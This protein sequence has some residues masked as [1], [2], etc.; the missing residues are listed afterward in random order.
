MTHPK[1]Y[2]IV[3]SL[4]SLL[5]LFTTLS[6][7]HSVRKLAKRRAAVEA[8]EA[9]GVDTPW[10]I[11]EKRYTT[12][13]YTCVCIEKCGH[14]VKNIERWPRKSKED[15]GQPHVSRGFF[16]KQVDLKSLV[17]KVDQVDEDSMV[18]NWMNWAKTKTLAQI[19]GLIFRSRSAI[20]L[21]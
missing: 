14:R 4:L 8:A 15:V 19:F 20:V 11:S 17:K 16:I 2:H 3:P 9:F 1:I 5:P 13:A 6:T 7:F 18:I 21:P 12:D 10:I